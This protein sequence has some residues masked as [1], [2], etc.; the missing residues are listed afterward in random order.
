MNAPHVVSVEKLV[1]G[2]DGLV[3]MDDGRV[4]FVP[5]VVAGEKVEIDL[6][7]TT[8]DFG[9]GRLL[10]VVEASP[11]RREPPC[12][13]VADGCG[14]CDWQHIEPAAQHGAKVA[15]VTEAFAR[16]ARMQI[17]PRLRVL[18]ASARRS[19]VRMVADH[20]GVLGFREGES[21]ETVRVASCMVAEQMVNDII[22]AP[23]LEGAGEVTIRVS[24]RTGERGVWC[25]EGQ[26]VRGLDESIARGA[27]GVVHMEAAGHRYR[28][29]MGSFFQSSEAAADLLVD[30]VTRRLNG[31]ELPQ[32]G[33]LVDAYGGVGL[34][35]RALSSRFDEIVLVESNQQACR[36]AITNLDDCAAVIDQS[37]MEHWNPCRAD[38]VVADPARQGLGK[39]GVAAI[40]DTEAPTVVLVSCDPVAGARDVR[41]LVDAGYGLG[42]VEVLDIFPE[43]H[44]VEV[45]SVLTREPD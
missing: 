40:V 7:S 19:T 44:H 2:G 30:V 16:T 35:S 11:D 31:L 1:A 33:L 23:L 10:R 21:N 22:A 25:H 12:P 38:V 27:R 20:N 18:D 5:G 13:H 4:V 24:P 41:M 32:G 8:N 14:G 17:E 36:D 15:L 6:V 34:F 42:D 3:R 26:M 45:V 29:S 39:G 28:V 9:R 37:N 43:T